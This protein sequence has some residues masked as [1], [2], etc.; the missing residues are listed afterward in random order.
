MREPSVAPVASDPGR[1]ANTRAFA[2]GRVNLIGEHTD[3]N[4]GLCLPFAIA[5]GVNVDVAA[6]E[7]ATIHAAAVD[8][9]EDDEFGVTEPLP[10]SGW[11][12]FVRGVVAELGSAGYHVRGGRVTISGSVP[13][14]SGLSSSAALEVALALAL[15]AHSGHPEPDRRTLARLCSRVEND[16]AGAQT[17]LLDQLAALFGRAGHAIRLDMRSLE[18][19]PVPLELGDWRL[20]AV[21]S[22]VEHAHAGSGYNQRRDECR[23]AAAM[24]GVETL[25][26]A[27]AA[28]AEDL[29]PPLG[30]RLRHVVTENERV[31]AA[32]EALQRGD[33]HG[34]GRVLD[35]SH[36][37]L[38]DDYETSVPAVEATVERL[39][40]RG[41]AGAR[42]VGGGFGGSVLALL[43]PDVPVPPGALVVEPGPAAHLR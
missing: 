26:D 11:R 5:A 22:G 19:T 29:P 34:L 33:L 17:G 36:A 37:S 31:D 4:A 27:S 9:G 16:W 10:A 13:R 40:Q 3:Y 1:R 2:P 24:L 7:D 43:P 38:R 6:S 15:L 39:K 23:L 12:A 18:I 32:M 41:A 35:A 42:M 28:D 30:A 8:L 25:R 14:G 21:D 20:V